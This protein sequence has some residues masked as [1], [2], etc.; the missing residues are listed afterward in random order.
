[1]EAKIKI[2]IIDDD[3]FSCDA[4]KALFQQEAS[5]I[6]VIFNCYSLEMFMQYC[7]NKNPIPDVVLVDMNHKTDNL[8]GLK[9]LQYIKDSMITCKPIIMTG[10]DYSKR[11]IEEAKLLGA[12]SFI[13][14]KE[15]IPEILKIIRIVNEGWTRFPEMPENKEYQ[16]LERKYNQ[17]T[18]QQKKVFKLYVMWG[19]KDEVAEKLNIEISTINGH[20]TDIRNTFEVLN[21][22]NLVQIALILNVI[23][24]YDINIKPVNTKPAAS[25]QN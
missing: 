3:K 23:S 16:R 15:N 2:A 5:D 9:I 17:L 21:D 6:E 8:G 25:S 22:A 24:L 13:K 14:K 7:D 11:I 12:R 18:P 19:N 20:L 1:M 4:Y 10:F